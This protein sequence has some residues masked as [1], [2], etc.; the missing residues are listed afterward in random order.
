MI[1]EKVTLPT[2]LPT[3]LIRAEEGKVLRRKSDGA[4]YG[5]EMLLGYTHYIGGV[6]QEPP[7][8]EVPEDYEEVDEPTILEEDDAA[9]A[10]AKHIVIA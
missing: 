3:S 5:T 6:R 1:I 10:E 9:M 8:F 7:H 4:C 2:G